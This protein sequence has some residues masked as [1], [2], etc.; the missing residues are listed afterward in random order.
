MCV[1]NPAPAGLANGGGGRRH[2]GAPPPEAALLPPTRIEIAERVRTIAAESLY[3]VL[4]LTDTATDEE[5]RAAH[6]RLARA[7]RPERLPPDLA[8]M[9]EACK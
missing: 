9:K 8:D 6:F 4:K 1:G 5:I 7:W 2:D 3:E